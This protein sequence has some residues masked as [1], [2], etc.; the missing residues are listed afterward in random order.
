MKRIDINIRRTN[1]KKITEFYKKIIVK[2]FV[3]NGRGNFPPA[4]YFFQ[5]DIQT[6]LIKL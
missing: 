3:K 6:K 1:I 5:F 4:Q 2:K